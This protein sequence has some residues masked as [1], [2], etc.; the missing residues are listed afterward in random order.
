MYGD[1]GVRG[2]KCVWVMDGY[3]GYKRCKGMGLGVR[4]VRG[5]GVRGVMSGCK[6]GSWHLL[7]TCCSVYSKCKLWDL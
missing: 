1:G 5:M 2:V 6:G 7:C 4:Y 3:K